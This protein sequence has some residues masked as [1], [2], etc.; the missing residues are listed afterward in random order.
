M[1]LAHSLAEHSSGHVGR[2][3]KVAH[4][5]QLRRHRASLAV[6]TEKSNSGYD[7]DP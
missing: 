6:T 5:A 2:H 4:P 1:D 3:S 7:H